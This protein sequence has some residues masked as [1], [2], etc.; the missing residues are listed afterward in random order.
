MLPSAL[1]PSHTPALETNF[2]FIMCVLCVKC[3]SR[4]LTWHIFF[5]L[6]S[7]CFLRQGLFLHLDL[8]VWLWDSFVSVSPVL[9]LEAQITTLAFHGYSGDPNLGPRV[10][11]ESTFPISPAQK[12]HF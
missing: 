1:P 10:C 3:G 9:E 12:S 6:S 11:I 7:L 5:D 2:V 4:M 8:I